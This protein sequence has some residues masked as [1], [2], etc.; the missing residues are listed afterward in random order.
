MR[1]YVLGPRV[2]NI[3]YILCVCISRLVTLTFDL[4]ILKLVRNVALANF[5]GTATIR[6]RFMGHWVNTAQTD[7]VTLEVMAPV[8]DADCHP[9]SAYHV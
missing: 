3:W 4:L 1:V 9:P 6:F 7:Q 2:R 8:A 5:V